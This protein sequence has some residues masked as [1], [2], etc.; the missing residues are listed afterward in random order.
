[1]NKVYT[2]SFGNLISSFQIPSTSLPLSFSTSQVPLPDP[3]FALEQRSHYQR[4][5]SSSA[6][7]AS[8]HSPIKVSG[9]SHH[10]PSSLGK[11]WHTGKSVSLSL[12]ATHPTHALAANR[13][14]E[15]DDAGDDALHALPWPR[16]ARVRVG[17]HG[18]PQ[19]AADD[20]DDDDDSSDQGTAATE[21]AGE[22][23]AAFDVWLGGDS[24]R[25]WEGTGDCGDCVCGVVGSLLVGDG[26]WRGIGIEAVGL[27][28]LKGCDFGVCLV[29]MKS[30]WG[31][32]VLW[33]RVLMCE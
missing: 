16:R 15:H 1:M 6:Q 14:T 18:S 26:G 10:H 2:M 21:E 8:A 32:L 7:N 13:R 19:S 33:R 3:S 20:D 4:N 11:Q 31:G 30:N 24:A 12:H 17:H 23:G 25:V 27:M 9:L 5:N 28:G 29:G 22:A